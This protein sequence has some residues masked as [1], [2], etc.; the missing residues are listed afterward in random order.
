MTKAKRLFGTLKPPLC[1]NYCAATRPQLSRLAAARGL[2]NLT[3]NLSRRTE[4]WRFGSTRLSRSVGN[5]SKPQ[6]NTGRGAAH[7]LK[8]SNDFTSDVRFI[9]LPTFMS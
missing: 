2:P 5:E 9:N 4:V 7:A 3:A 6:Q 8:P 1:A